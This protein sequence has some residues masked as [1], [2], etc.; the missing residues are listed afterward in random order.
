MNK[1][2]SN[3]EFTGLPLCIGCVY[4]FA[5]HDVLH[6]RNSLGDIQASFKYMFDKC[7]SISVRDLNVIL[8][9]YT[10][11]T[12]TSGFKS[13]ITT[14]FL[15]VTPSSQCTCTEPTLHKLMKLMF[16]ICVKLLRN[17]VYNHCHSA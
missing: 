10:R 2:Y 4:M 16:I 14:W 8:A 9:S 17:H 1:W 15:V 7:Q 13:P 6:Y 11:T 5:H 3:I 12:E